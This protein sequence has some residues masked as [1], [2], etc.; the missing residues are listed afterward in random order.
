MKRLAAAVT[1][2]SIV[3][4]LPATATA[5]GPVEG[6]DVCGEQGCAAVPLD[7][8]HGGPISMDVF[9]GSFSSAL[10]KGTDI[11]GGPIVT[12]RTGQPAFHT[13]FGQSAEVAPPL[14]GRAGI[15]CAGRQCV[16]RRGQGQRQQKGKQTSF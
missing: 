5:K 7:K 15:P 2:L 14:R 10:E 13:V 1:T 12:R 6:L 8:Q 3:L 9:F 11:G 16:C 4:T